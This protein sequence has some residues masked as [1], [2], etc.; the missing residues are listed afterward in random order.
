M[1]HESS[2]YSPVFSIDVAP[3]SAETHPP[4]I[5]PSLA[6]VALLRQLLHSQERQNKLLEQLVAGHNAAQK[7]RIADL[8]QW[9][10]ANPHLAKACRQAAEA[11][12]R[13]QAQF[14]EQIAFE[15][16]DNEEVLTDGEFMLGEFVDRFGP[17]L[18]HLNGILQVLA[19]LSTTSSANSAQ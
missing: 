13:I 8:Q 3:A 19:Q 7:Q 18:A 15:V 2:Q 11:L 14:L 16:Q 5:D 6:V 4:T 1:A 12:S 17:R 9:R 10:D